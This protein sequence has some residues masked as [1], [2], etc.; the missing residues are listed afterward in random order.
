VFSRQRFIVALLVGCL[1]QLLMLAFELHASLFF[2][3]F[4]SGCVYWALNGVY[5]IVGFAVVLAAV[6]W[7]SIAVRVGVALTLL[8]GSLLVGG[9]ARAT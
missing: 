7:H 4:S 6:R 9:F 1:V 3:R 8:V 5:M 2:A